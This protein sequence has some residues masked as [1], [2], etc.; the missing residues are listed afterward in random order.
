MRAVGL[1]NRWIGRATLLGLTTWGLACGE[2]STQP[3][4]DSIV[5]Q[6]AK[7]TSEGSGDPEVM[8]VDPPD[9]PQDTRLV[10]T[11][12]GSGFDKTA[13]V[14]MLLNEE[15][16]DDIT[17]NSTKFVNSKRLRADITIAANA[18]VKKFDVAVTV[19]AAN[20][21]KR[22][23]G[24]ELFEVTDTT[25]E[26]Q[27]GFDLTLDDSK[28][29]RSDGGDQYQDAIDKVQVSTGS[30]PGFRFD[31]NGNQKLQG[32]NDTR[33]VTLDFTGTAGE[34]LTDPN[35]PTGIDFRFDIQPSANSDEGLNLCAL[36]INNGVGT[37]SAKI[38]FAVPGTKEGY[39]LRYGG[40]TS[41]GNDCGA[42]GVEEIKVT[43][44][45]E[46]TWELVSGPTACL[47]PDRGEIMAVIAMPIAFTITAQP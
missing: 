45:G 31:T 37:V 8:K 3:T 23:I 19:T 39:R 35:V 47:L 27:I 22:G 24:I 9:A 10:L 14:E 41:T 12:T 16:T 40:I 30:G 21:R 38:R 42:L 5:I 43:R 7:S 2:T 25:Q 15:S 32:R 20:R 34:G 17:T 1:S 33:L 46:T 26:C 6:A 44:K 4:I 36:D 18:A 29:V 11:V 13:K 28:P